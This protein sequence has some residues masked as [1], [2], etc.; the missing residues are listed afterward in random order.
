MKKLK[1][2]TGKKKFYVYNADTIVRV[3]VVLY[4]NNVHSCF[5]LFFMFSWIVI[6]LNT[7]SYALITSIILKLETMRKLT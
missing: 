1:T 2:N 3:D 7:N 5:S 4:C 6:W